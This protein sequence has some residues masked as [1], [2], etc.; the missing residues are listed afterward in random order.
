MWSGGVETLGGLQIVQ[1]TTLPE[2]TRLRLISGIS[3]GLVRFAA[4]LLSARV[5][6]AWC[7]RTG[8]REAHTML[9]QHERRALSDIE[10]HLRASEPELVRLLEC[11][12]AWAPPQHRR[13]GVR[14]VVGPAG[15]A[16]GAFLLAVAFTVRSADVLLLAVTILLADAAWWTLLAVTALARQRILNNR[17]SH[18][19]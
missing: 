14:R 16:L 13:R 4:D 19:R 17:E 18:R 11:F 10:E 8:T 5:V 9:S 7:R 3:A 12:H 6:G 2:R 15:L 1:A